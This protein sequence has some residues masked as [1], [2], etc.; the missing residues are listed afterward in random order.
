MDQKTI[1]L[2]LQMKG[3]ALDAIHHDLVQT[4][5]E[6]DVAYSTVTKYARSSSFAIEKETA[7]PA[8]IDAA[9]DAVDQTMLIALAEYPF[10]SVGELS[11]RI[12]LPR[13]PIHRHLTRSLDS[14]MRHLRWVPHFLT[15]EQKKLRVH[16]AT[17][18]LGILAIQR[19]RQ[20]H[21][22]VTLDESWF[23]WNS[24][25][26][27]MWLPPGDAVPDRER[28]IIQSPKLML[29]IVW[30]PSGLHVV[31]CSPTGCKFNAHGYTTRIFNEVADWRR[32][33]GGTR[34]PELWVRADNARPHTAKVAI[35]YIVHNAMKR[36]PHPPYSP[37]LAP[38]DFFLFGH[39]KRKLMGYHAEA[40]AELFLRVGAILAEIPRETLSAVFHRWMDRLRTCIDMPGEYVG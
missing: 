13:S 17:E 18:L 40:A 2:Y 30:S 3:M 36:A 12:C 7:A 38:S 20:W 14:T 26:D 11:R 21:D 4:L 16:M 29:A 22:I 10:S 39:V 6:K 1:V 8:P 32:R 24:D 35:D 27:L 9:A 19:T 37:D 23:Y 28:Y 31:N 33:S 5:G 34:P 25:H 15:P